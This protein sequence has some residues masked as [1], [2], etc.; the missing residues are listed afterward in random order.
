MDDVQDSAS[1]ESVL[2]LLCPLGP[3][4]RGDG[5]RLIDIMF[6]G[7]GRGKDARLIQHPHE[8][9]ELMMIMMASVS[10]WPSALEDL[11]EPEVEDPLRQFMLSDL[12]LPPIHLPALSDASTDTESPGT[13]SSGTITHVPIFHHKSQPPPIILTLHVSARPGCGGITWPA[14]QVLAEYL[15]HKGTDAIKNKHIIELGS[16]T[17]LVGL[18]AGKLGART[19]HIT[20]QIPL[21]D[22]MHRNVQ[23]N[24][25]SENV[26]VSELD[27]AL[28]VS[29]ALSTPSPDLILAADC[30]YFEP[31]FPLLVNTLVN[32]TSTTTSTGDTPE[33]WFCY[34]K[35]RKVPFSSPSPFPY[36]ISLIISLITANSI[37]SPLIFI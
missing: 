12:D 23:L 31:A 32:L 33:I 37:I 11:F 17:G 16:G 27:W 22:I 5:D 6:L 3:W 1:L 30:V 36:L 18:V 7:E 4:T 29:D 10:P 34:K 8:G 15:V 13:D 35:R 19:V 14:G 24:N 2:F 9:T 28:P 25:L 20:D 21:L 26:H